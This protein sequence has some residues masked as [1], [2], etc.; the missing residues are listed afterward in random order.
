MAKA[1]LSN[2]VE[3]NIHQGN[4]KKI[5]R[6]IKLGEPYVHLSTKDGSKL[7]HIAVQAHQN[8][9]VECLLEKGFSGFY[10]KDNK[11]RTPVELAEELGYADLVTLFH[12]YKTLTELN[13]QTT[14]STSSTSTISEPLAIKTLGLQ[15]GA[16]CSPIK[17]EYTKEQWQEKLKEV[18]HLAPHIVDRLD[19]AKEVYQRLHNI[20]KCPAKYQIRRQIQ[21]IV[22]LEAIAYP[23]LFNNTISSDLL[24]NAEPS[25]RLSWLNQ[26]SLL[27][28]FK[29]VI[30]LC[31]EQRGK[32][33][34]QPNEETLKYAAA[35]GNI[36]LVNWL[37]DQMHIQPNQETLDKAALSSSFELMEWLI[38][39]SVDKQATN[40]LIPSMQ[41]LDNAVLS[42]NYKSVAWLNNNYVRKMEGFTPGDQTVDFAAISGNQEILNYLVNCEDNEVS[43]SPTKETLDG[44][45]E[46]GNL[47][48]VKLLITEAIADM[49][50]EPDSM[51]L[52]AAAY[53]G[54]LELVKWLTDEEREQQCLDPDE[55][56]F[57]AAALS[58]SLKLVKWFVQENEVDD[59]NV[60]EIMLNLAAYSGNIKL[61]KWLLDK[62][63]D[64][65]QIVPTLNTFYA[66]MLSGNIKL[67]QWLID[68]ARD[69]HQ[70][71]FTEE[72]LRAAVELKNSGEIVDPSSGVLLELG[73][74]TVAIEELEVYDLRSAFKLNVAQWLIDNNAHGKQELPDKRALDSAAQDDATLTTSKRLRIG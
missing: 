16:I 26:A 46:V 63:W 27:G 45:A 1:F 7:L 29:L 15:R 52:N 30:Y 4:Y 39:R 44:A 5:I 68:K 64:D 50:L 35:S 19:S 48:M 13:T 70:I 54:N 51:T 8:R 56:T 9:L 20:W 47:A 6:D 25:T 24:K 74:N 11:G 62:E 21:H 37:I 22:I 23:P 32:Y 28:N 60:L 67:V 34:V 71:D 65:Q 38:K 57:K 72:L 14:S 66:A 53:S 49:Q 40:K 58:G 61:V 41:T 10:S 42:G 2:Q 12:H 55:D 59:V 33:Q 69:A 43:I 3:E 36:T 73:L 18:F 17:R 31:D